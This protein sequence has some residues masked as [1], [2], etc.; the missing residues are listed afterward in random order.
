MDW[1][2]VEA[3]WSRFRS[4]VHANWGRLT[5]AHLDVIAG[6]RAHLASKLSEAY[7]VTDVEAERQIKSFEA[8]NQHPR[9]VSFR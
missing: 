2:F 9:P 7:G 1:N 3:S 4:E 6:R 5:S 8:R